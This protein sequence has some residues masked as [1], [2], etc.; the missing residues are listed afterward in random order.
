MLKF[1]FML[2]KVK[3]MS[4]AKSKKNSLGIC[5]I[6]GFSYLSLTM[7]KMSFVE[8]LIE[9]VSLNLLNVSLSG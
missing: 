4:L 8:N 9:T 1:R 6:V 2:C 7:N 5:Q 3:K